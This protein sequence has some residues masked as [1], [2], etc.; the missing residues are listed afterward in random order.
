MDIAHRTASNLAHLVSD[1]E[2]LVKHEQARF[3]VEPLECVGRLFTGGTQFAEPR[4]AF[5]AAVEFV[6]VDFKELAKE[7]V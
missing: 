2:Y 3:S 1:T 6:A 7:R 5:L 4:L